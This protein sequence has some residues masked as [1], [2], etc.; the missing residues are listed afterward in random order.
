[1]S[2]VCASLHSWGKTRLFPWQPLCIH[3]A[4]AALHPTWKHQASLLKITGILLHLYSAIKG[5]LVVALIVCLSGECNPILHFFSPYS[6]PVQS[7][8]FL[9]HQ[10]WPSPLQGGRSVQ[11]AGS[12]IT[13]WKK[14]KK[15]KGGI[16]FYW[17][18][19]QRGQGSVSCCGGRGV[20]ARQARA[21]GDRGEGSRGAGSPLSLSARSRSL[22]T[23]HQGLGTAALPYTA[24]KCGNMETHHV[25]VQ[26][27]PLRKL[28]QHE[29]CEQQLALPS[30]TV[31]RCT[32]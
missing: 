22:R 18:A 4:V 9:C 6:F 1:M 13:L 5:I 24:H 28:K 27:L 23:P 29:L 11:L 15:K 20:V 26:A 21:N 30:V 3:A 8:L 16:V 17:A 7:P 32:W 19:F 10:D 25:H 12:K 14:K 2:G 31:S